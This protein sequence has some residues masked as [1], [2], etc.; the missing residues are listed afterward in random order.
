MGAYVSTCAYLGSCVLQ[1]EWKISGE[2]MGY[3]FHFQCN[4]PK[5]IYITLTNSLL[6]IFA[7]ENRTTL[8]FLNQVF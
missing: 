5:Y 3:G 6:H 8:T 2:I 7:R 1:F 4:S